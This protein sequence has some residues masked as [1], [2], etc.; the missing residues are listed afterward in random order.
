MD[1]LSKTMEELHLM[2]EECELTCEELAKTSRDFDYQ[3][4]EYK[5]KYIQACILAREMKLSEKKLDELITMTQDTYLGLEILK[6]EYLHHRYSRSEE[7]LKS[8]RAK[9]RSYLNTLEAI[10]ITLN[11]RK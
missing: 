1:L 5:L 6:D 10:H 4:E 7:I 2:K 8:L 9:E 11:S 3:R